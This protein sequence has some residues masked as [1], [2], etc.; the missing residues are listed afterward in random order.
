[1]RRADGLYDISRRQ[2]CAVAGLTLIVGSCA[3]NNGGAVQTGDLGDN[4]NPDAGN[5]HHDAN[6]AVD[7]QGGPD[8]S[9]GLACTGSPIDVGAA[10]TFVANTPVYHSTGKF[11]IVR[12]SGGL[13]AVTAVCTHEGA[14]C[15]V[16]GSDFYCPR[17]GAEFT[18]NG[19]VTRGPAFL[20]LTHYSMCDMSNGHV[21][22]NTSQTVGASVR[23]SS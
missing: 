21:G 15:V 22:V 6:G 3:D 11:F 17:H 14:T 8:S 7:A 4:L 19:V 16:Q 18:F 10:S 1:M 12:D 5:A 9:T 23:L 2:F 13:Y 20:P